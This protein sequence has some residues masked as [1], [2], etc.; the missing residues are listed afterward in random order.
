[1]RISDWS[2]DVCSSD[3]CDLLKLHRYVEQRIVFN[4]ENLQH[5][6]AGLLHHARARI[7]VFIDAMPQ[8]HPAERIV[9]IGRASGRAR[10]CQ[11]L[12]ISVVA[13]A[14]NKKTTPQITTTN[15]TTKAMQ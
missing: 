9:Q 11:Y 4:A 12:S 1:M 5:F 10:V 2:S 8:A 6:M 3:L 15:H 7:V 14:L 13:V